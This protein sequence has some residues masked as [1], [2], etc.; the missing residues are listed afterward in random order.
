MSVQITVD[1]SLTIGSPVQLGDGDYALSRFGLRMY[2][3]FP[4]GDR[5][6]M[7]REVE[8]QDHLI[9]VVLNAFSEL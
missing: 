1:P 5:F 8:K 6:L 3:L 7:F 9:H 2:D 4:G